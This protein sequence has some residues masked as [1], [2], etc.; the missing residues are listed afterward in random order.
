M[1]R[2]RTI[3][4]YRNIDLSLFALMLVICEYVIVR[5]ANSWFAGQPYTVSLAA[6]I[7]AIVYMRWGYWGGIHAMLGGLVFCFLTGAEG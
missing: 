6:A 1:K 2:Q 3:Q 7:T 4:E 5:A